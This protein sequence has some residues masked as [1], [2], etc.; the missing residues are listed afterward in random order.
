MTL[1]SSHTCACMYMS[2]FACHCLTVLITVYLLRV[3]AVALSLSR[4]L[5]GCR[6]KNALDL[7]AKLCREKN[8]FIGRVFNHF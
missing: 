3:P 1:Y 2:S 6:K 7:G 8:L 4:L 5:T